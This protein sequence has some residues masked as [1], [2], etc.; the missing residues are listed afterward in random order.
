MIFFL[1]LIST[2]ILFSMSA[3]IPLFNHAD[4]SDLII[5]GELT[6]IDYYSGDVMVENINSMRDTAY[7]K[8]N[9][10]YKNSS[11]NT[12]H[13]QDSIKLLMPTK[14][15]RTRAG[16]TISSFSS[17]SYNVGQNG[18]WLLNKKDN[19]FYADNYQS[20]QTNSK[21]TLIRELCKIEPH[22]LEFLNGVFWSNISEVRQS[23]KLSMIDPTDS[24]FY[25]NETNPLFLAVRYRKYEII[26][27]IVDYGFNINFRNENNE[28]ALFIALS[29]LTDDLKIIEI[30]LLNGI[31]TKIIN[32]R[33]ISII[34][35]INNSKNK[36]KI[37]ELFHKQKK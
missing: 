24:I 16:F 27:D 4:R 3:T 1:I 13:N 18:I 6:H 7:I 15:G 9:K 22:V 21:D 35:L 23:L 33:G 17:I 14:Y 11:D 10:I 29:G 20:F 25:Y 36:E 37:L 31:E 12:Y 28:N 2:T 30:L 5:Q 19:T 32:E 34:D 26:Q 8:I